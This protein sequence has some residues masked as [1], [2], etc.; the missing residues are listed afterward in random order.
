M[1]KNRKS[2]KDND[3]E[4]DQ[5]DALLDEALRMTFPASDPIAISFDHVPKRGGSEPDAASDA[6]T[7]RQ[8]AKRSA[9]L[10]GRKK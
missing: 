1:T 9:A 6:T 3:A 5:A 4:R 2:P 10:V 8:P 7:A